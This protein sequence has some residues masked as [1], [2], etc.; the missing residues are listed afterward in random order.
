MRWRS[1]QWA[2]RSKRRLT[3]TQRFRESVV[4]PRARCALASWPV[5]Q[6]KLSCVSGKVSRISA[7]KAARRMV[8][9]ETGEEFAAVACRGQRGIEIVRGEKVADSLDG[10]VNVVSFID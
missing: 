1:V 9:L 7:A 5:S 2:R 8:W 10:V 3:R 6:G 4:K